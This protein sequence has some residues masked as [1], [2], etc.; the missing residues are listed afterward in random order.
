MTVVNK[1]T[2][3]ISQ[4]VVCDDSYS[5]VFAHWVSQSC[6][7]GVCCFTVLPF[8]WEE[9]VTADGSRYYINHTNQ[10]TSWFHP[11]TKTLPEDSPLGFLNPHGP[12][13]H[14]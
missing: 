8:G 13:T 10:T 2:S 4:V 1:N 7:N 9:A 11:A 6:W 5:Q 14:A 3:V 12:E